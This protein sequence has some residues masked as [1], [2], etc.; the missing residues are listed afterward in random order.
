MLPLLPPRQRSA[1]EDNSTGTT[2]GTNGNVKKEDI[3]QIVDQLLG[4][5]W[6]GKRDTPVRSQLDRRT[7]PSW[8]AND[9]VFDSQKRN[10]IP[11]P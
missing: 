8:S 2:N 1:K 11:I 4:G 9:S 7:K 6:L 3:N 5:D 10:V